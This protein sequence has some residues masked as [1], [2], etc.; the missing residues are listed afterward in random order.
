MKGPNAVTVFEG[1]QLHIPFRF[2]T[3]PSYE[4]YRCNGCGLVVFSYDP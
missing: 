4:G 1:V 3:A 2:W